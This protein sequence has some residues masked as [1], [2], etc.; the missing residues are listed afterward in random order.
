M[1][2]KLTGATLVVVEF[3]GTVLGQSCAV[4]AN[5]IDLALVVSQPHGGETG[6]GGGTV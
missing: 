5:A 6:S 1:L 2:N 3:A 4:K